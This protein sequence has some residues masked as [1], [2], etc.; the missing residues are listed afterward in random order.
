VSEPTAGKAALPPDEKPT[1]TEVQYTLRPAHGDQLGLV[2]QLVL[3][4][5]P[6]ILIHVGLSDDGESLAFDVDATGPQDPAELATTLELIA[7]VLR[8]GEPEGTEPAEEAETE[9]WV[10]GRLI[11]TSRPG[12]CV[13]GVGTTPGLWCSAC[14]GA[15]A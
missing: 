1:Q 14:L 5:R 3:G 15:S 2:T 13:H 6:V 11:V 7:H 10:D 8:S 9:E 4:A 12:I